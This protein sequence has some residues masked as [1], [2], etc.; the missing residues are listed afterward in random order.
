MLNSRVQQKLMEK[1]YT[2]EMNKDYITEVFDHIRMMLPGENGMP[3]LSRGE[4]AQ[5]FSLIEKSQNDYT[6]EM[7]CEEIY[8]SQIQEFVEY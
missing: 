2:E 3:K 1:E 6:T 8:L 4:V 7:L 5:I